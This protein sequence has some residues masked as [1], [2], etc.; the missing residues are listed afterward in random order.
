MKKF[1]SIL[2][3][4]AAA[5]TCIS[6]GFVS[7]SAATESY[8]IL[9]VNRD[10]KVN[11]SDVVVIN[12][13]LRGDSH[14]TDY[15]RFDVNKSLTIDS[16]DSGTIMA[17]VL[18]T[19]CKSSYFSRKSGNEV[20]FPTVSG[21]KP[22][23]LA[24][25]IENMCYEK[26][27]YTENKQL[28]DYYLTPANSPNYYA[29]TREIIDGEDSRYAAYGEENTGIVKLTI[30]TNSYGTGFIVGDHQIATAAHCVYGGGNSSWYS[31]EITTYDSNGLLTGTKLTP[32]EAHVPKLYNGVDG[33]DNM[34]DYALITVKENLSD[35][36]HFD[37]GTS[38]NV[39]ASDFSKVPLYVTG[40]PGLVNDSLNTSKRL[41]SDEGHV[42]DKDNTSV[43][44]YDVDTSGGNSGSPVYTITRTEKDGKVSYIY[45]ALAVHHG[46]DIEAPVY[47]CG[48]LITKYHL[49]F[50][51]NN[52]N[53]SY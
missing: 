27:S 34:Y 3:I 19:S 32:I 5:V 43:L 7:V 24:S 18:M 13:Y 8:D 38:Y 30:N 20:A 21:F 40:C 29:D 14:I 23:G 26:Y 39:T 12:N 50:Y 49:Q 10:G 22:D 9:D 46:S 2:S 28:K 37:L 1:K 31:V 44:H 52:P 25:S 51:K 11:V 35:Y 16:V 4:I 6:S 36:V 53:I 42:S 47:N 41:Y 45:T 15:N 33:K 17:K 48:S